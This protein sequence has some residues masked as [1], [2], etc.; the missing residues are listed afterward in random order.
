MPFFPTPTQTAIRRSS[1]SLSSA[2]ST[3]SAAVAAAAAAEVRQHFIYFILRPFSSSFCSYV[4]PPH[5]LKLVG[6]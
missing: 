3:D 2:S 6:V 5:P 4:T 1:S